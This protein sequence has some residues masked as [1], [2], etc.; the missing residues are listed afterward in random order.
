MTRRM[1]RV[2]FVAAMFGSALLSGCYGNPSGTESDVDEALASAA[3]SLEAVK[4]ARFFTELSGAEEVPPRMTPAQGAATFQVTED[5]TAILYKVFV[6]N[7]R[8]VIAAHI[9]L[10]ARGVNG[11][12]VAFLAGDFPPGGGRRD[13]LLAEG[14]ITAADLE[15][16]LAGM[17]ICALLREMK[18]GNTYVNVHTDDGVAPANTGPGDFPGGEIRGQIS[19]ACN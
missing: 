12:I 11:P 17:P 8:N 6:S 13:G 7:I 4:G 10:G 19:G 3:Q 9:H 2:T 16:P 18:A 14:R 15:G 1:A 5:G